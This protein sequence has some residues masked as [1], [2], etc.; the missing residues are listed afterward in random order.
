VLYDMV[1][2]GY[3]QRAQHC[4]GCGRQFWTDVP[5]PPPAPVP[6]LPAS[7]RGCVHHGHDRPCPE[8]RE[9][10]RRAK[11]IGF[12]RRRVLR[13]VCACGTPIPV[14]RFRYCSDRCARRAKRDLLGRFH[15]NGAG[16]KGEEASVPADVPEVNGGAGQPTDEDL[17]RNGYQGDPAGNVA[18]GA[19]EPPTLLAAGAPAQDEAMR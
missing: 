13:S 19:L 2:S 4:A 18:Q 5:A 6:A 1:V 11:S 10:L 16:A 12:E 8:C 17:P 7:L 9:I 3:P 14:E 15:A